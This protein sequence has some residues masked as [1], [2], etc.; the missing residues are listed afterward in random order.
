[1]VSDFLRDAWRQFWKPYADLGYYLAIDPVLARP[2][3]R[4][5]VRLNV[6]NP[7]GPPLIDPN[8]L[9]NQND[10]EALFEVTNFVVNVL[11]QYPLPFVTPFPGIP[12]CEDCKFF[13]ELYLQCHIRNMAR[14]YY[15]FVG[16]AR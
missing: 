5:T 9:S 12:N 8:Y 7:M 16:T 6:S 10:Y 15:D 1:M 4:G 13:C 14:G 2:K 3:S 11:R